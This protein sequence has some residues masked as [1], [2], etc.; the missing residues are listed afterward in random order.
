MTLRY[1]LVKPI[2]RICRTLVQ[3][4]LYLKANTDTWK[5]L[6]LLQ[7]VLQSRFKTTEKLFLGIPYAVC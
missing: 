4:T 2:R 7:I 6:I 1:L 5:I 3:Y